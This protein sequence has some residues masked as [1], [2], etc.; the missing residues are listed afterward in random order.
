[1]CVCLCVCVPKSGYLKLSWDQDNKSG[2]QRLP[3]AGV[4]VGH[5]IWMLV[6][7]TVI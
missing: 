3:P 2:G 4:V 6:I 5:G 1:M 7:H